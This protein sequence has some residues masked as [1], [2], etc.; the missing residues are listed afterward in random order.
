M[1]GL[2]G[3]HRIVAKAPSRAAA[4]YA[5]SGEPNPSREAMHFQGLAGVA[6]ARR[7]ET[8][9]RTE[10]RTEKELVPSNQHDSELDAPPRGEPGDV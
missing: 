6:A 1:T 7:L 8:A 10:E 2:F 5:A 9:V 4:Q 3:G